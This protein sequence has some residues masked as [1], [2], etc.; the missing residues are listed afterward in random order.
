MQA[1]NKFIYLILYVCLFVFFVR[2]IIDS[3]ILDEKQ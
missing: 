2:N 1:H 3:D